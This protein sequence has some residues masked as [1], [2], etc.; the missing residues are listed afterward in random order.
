MSAFDFLVNRSD[1]NQTRLD[2]V[3]RPSISTGQVL[4]KLNRFALTANNIT[5]GVAGDLIGYWQFFPTEEGQG[6]IPVWG[7]GT[8][9]TSECSEVKVGER[10]YGYYPMSSYLAVT[11]G[12]IG[13]NS[14][15]DEVE[16]RQALPAVYNQYAHMRDDNGY[17]SQYDNHQ[18]IYRPLFTTSFV[19]DDFFLDNEFFGASQIILSSA[20]SKTA[21]GMAYML[22]SL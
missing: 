15:V 21:F 2:S 11:P 22:K 6:R 14:F 10:Y 17:Q 4:L 13:R 9:V 1:L 8:V 18:V 12:K 7:I 16:H 3:E 19:L 5:Y 20:S